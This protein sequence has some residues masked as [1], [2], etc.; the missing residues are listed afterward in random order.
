MIRRPPRSTLFPYTTLFRSRVDEA[1]GSGLGTRA[2]RG[3]AQELGDLLEGLL[4]GGEADALQAPPREVLQPL[5]REREVA[6]PL[7]ARHGASASP[8]PRSPSRRSPSSWSA[9]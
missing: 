4:G 5:E 2:S 3:A 9:E 7:V 6:A 8:P 1:G